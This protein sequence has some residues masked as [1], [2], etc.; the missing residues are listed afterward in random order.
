M[1]IYVNK[2]SHLVRGVSFAE[3]IRHL[4]GSKLNATY[5]LLSADFGDVFQE[6]CQDVPQ[7]TF[8]AAVAVA[9]TTAEVV[10]IGLD[11]IVE[12]ALQPHQ[13]NVSVSGGG[14]TSN[15]YGWNDNDKKRKK[16]DNSYKP[17]KFGR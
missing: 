15:S 3:G 9:E 12:L 5:P 1:N 10:C 14:G 16:N 7:E 8:N 4:T 6:L 17:F 2:A 11:A 13:A